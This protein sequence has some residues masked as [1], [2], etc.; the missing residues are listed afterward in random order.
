MGGEKGALRS[1]SSHLP[2]LLLWFA[3]L[4]GTGQPFRVRCMLAT[5]PLSPWLR[6]ACVHAAITRASAFDL[7]LSY[8]HHPLKPWAILAIRSL[9]VIINSAL[10]APLHTILLFHILII[11]VLGVPL[12]KIC[13]FFHFHASP[14]E[15]DVGGR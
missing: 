1:L 7:P 2:S 6:I 14:G 15:L 5:K 8:R 4:T 11:W 9:L 12:H 3:W 10:V 13:L